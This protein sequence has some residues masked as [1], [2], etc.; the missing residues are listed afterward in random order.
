MVSRMIWG[1]PETFLSPLKRIRTWK[2]HWKKEYISLQLLFRCPYTAIVSFIPLLVTQNE[3]PE[4][5]RGEVTLKTSRVARSQFLCRGGP[6]QSTIAW[7]NTQVKCQSSEVQLWRATLISNACV[8]LP[9]GT[10][11]AE[12][13]ELIKDAWLDASLWLIQQFLYL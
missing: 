13:Q 7:Q 8:G 6:L 2:Q 1:N 9:S 11:E 3:F 5:M 12:C 4:V 10:N